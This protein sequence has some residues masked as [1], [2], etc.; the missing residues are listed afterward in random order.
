MLVEED[1]TGQLSFGELHQFAAELPQLGFYDIKIAFVDRHIDQHMMNQ[2]GENV[3]V[4]RGIDVK[5]FKQTANAEVW[6][7]A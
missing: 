1:L 6:L 2:F 4:N 7:Q 5:V 3:A